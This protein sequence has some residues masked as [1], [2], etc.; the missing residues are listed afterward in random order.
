MYGIRVRELRR[1][2]GLTQR[3]L[4]RL[5]GVSGAVIGQVERGERL[6]GRKTEQRLRAVL[7][8]LPERPAK[9]SRR[10]DLLSL[11]REGYPPPQAR[12]S[13]R[14]SAAGHPSFGRV[15]AGEARPPR[16]RRGGLR[17]SLPPPASPPK[18]K[19]RRF[20]DGAAIRF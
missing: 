18:Q 20:P 4:G 3:Q 11:L 19:P 9:P 14:N 16:L 15:Q 8:A 12:K 5:C 6:P 13:R 17:P 10:A 7:G 2:R 1:Q